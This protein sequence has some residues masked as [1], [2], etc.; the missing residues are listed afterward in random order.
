MVEVRPEPGAAEVVADRLFVLGASAVAEGDGGFLVADLPPATVREL[1]LW[2]DEACVAAEIR[3]REVDPSW[4][5][6][7]REHATAYRVGPF[8]VRPPWVSEAALAGELELVVDPGPT[9]GSGG[10][11]TTRM[12]LAALATIVYGGESVLDVGVGS[13][14]LAVGALALGAGSAVGV[15][16]DPNAADA[17]RAC[18]EANGF[19]QRY[20][21][22]A[23]GMGAVTDRYDIVVANLL[24][25][26]IEELGPELRSVC[27]PGAAI[28]ISGLLTS[29]R[30]R[31]LA[32]LDA[33]AVAPELVLAEADWT[34]LV[35]R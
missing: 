27:A 13:G 5:D 10:H 32:A 26:T 25:G 18:A 4:V 24:I 34:A 22:R 7:W 9:F 21:F 16:I 20:R 12:C 30:E 6:G 29:Q 33:S 8:L 11:P 2:C 19:Q 23:G 3:L 15:D 17:S 31:A 35:V 1:E 14:I 28:V